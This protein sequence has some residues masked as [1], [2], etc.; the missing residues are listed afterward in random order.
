M[1]GS[2]TPTFARLDVNAR[3]RS[4]AFNF[5]LLRRHGF[6]LLSPF[7][8]DEPADKAGTGC[9]Q[10]ERPRDW[11]CCHQVSKLEGGTGGAEG[12]GAEDLGRENSNQVMVELLGVT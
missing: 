3:P 5:L 12:D 9:E 1:L 10:R 4:Q 8:P 2:L 11:C 7:S 6:G